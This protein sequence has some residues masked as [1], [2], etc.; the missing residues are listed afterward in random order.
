MYRSEKSSIMASPTKSRKADRQESG[1]L[2]ISAAIANH[3][4]PTRSGST[5]R[6]PTNGEMTVGNASTS[7]ATAT[8]DESTKLPPSPL[9]TPPMGSNPS[10][11]AEEAISPRN[12]LPVDAIRAAMTSGTCLASDTEPQQQQSPGT[13]ANSSPSSSNQSHQQQQQQQQQHP[14]GIPHVYHDYAKLSG[15]GPAFI[16]KKTGGVT[17]RKYYTIQRQ[18]L[19]KK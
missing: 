10:Q 5:G 12:L 19:A 9:V 6:I 1:E 4:P 2:K 14:R 13:K 15:P 16:R 7:N 8:S 18:R 11:T 3:R 17:Q